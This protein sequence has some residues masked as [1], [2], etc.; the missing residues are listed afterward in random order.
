MGNM[1]VSSGMS[2]A[3]ARFTLRLMQQFSAT[4]GRGAPS[5]RPETLKLLDARI[6]NHWSYARLASR[7]CDCGAVQHGELCRERIRKRLKEL[8]SYLAKYDIQYRDAP[9]E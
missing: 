7:M 3:E 5:K 6:A 4:H 1:F 9:G 2:Y 8:E